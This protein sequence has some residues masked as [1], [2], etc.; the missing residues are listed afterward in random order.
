MNPVRGELILPKHYV[1]LKPS[2]QAILNAAATIYAGYLSA[3]RV[4]DGAE[5]EWLKRSLQEAIQLAR[6]ADESVMADGEFD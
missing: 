3:G 1:S 2:E 6:A 5:S 4:V